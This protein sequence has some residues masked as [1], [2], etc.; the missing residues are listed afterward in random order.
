MLV[1]LNCTCSKS[2]PKINVYFYMFQLINKFQYAE[3]FF[4]FKDFL[5]ILTKMRSLYGYTSS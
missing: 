5:Y 4:H 2:S 3:F 1:C